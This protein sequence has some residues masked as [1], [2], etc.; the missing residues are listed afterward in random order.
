MHADGSVTVAAEEALS[1]SD[2]CLDTARKELAN[3]QTS[4]AAAKN[5]QEKAEAQI[6]IDTI[7]AM[8]K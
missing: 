2:I 1:E 3:A 5:E 4:L 7:E 6:A 8:L